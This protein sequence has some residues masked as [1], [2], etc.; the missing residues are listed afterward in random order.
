MQERN[1]N[2]TSAADVQSSVS[3]YERLHLTSTTTEERN[4]N[5]SNLVNSYYDLATLFYEW[6]WGASFHFSNR[7]PYET[8]DEATRRHEFYLASKLNLSGALGK[9][10]GTMNG[11]MNGQSKED[12]E[13]VKEG[14][15]PS[16]ANV[17]VLD[18]GCGIGGPMRNICKFTGADVTGLTLNQYQVD[19]GNELCVADAHFK[20][21]KKS[22]SGL[23]DVR[24]RSVQ[25]DFM[26][27]PFENSSF[28]AAYAIEATCHAPD[29]VGCYSEIYRV[30]KPGAIFACY[31]WCLTD[32]YNALVSS[33]F[34]RLDFQMMGARLTNMMHPVCDLLVFLLAANDASQK[35]VV[36]SACPLGLGILCGNCSS[37]S[38]QCS[39]NSSGFALKSAQSILGTSGSM[40]SVSFGCLSKN[41][42]TCSACSKCPILGLA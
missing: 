29:R 2:L 35:A 39:M 1:K 36:T 14:S 31:E 6:G 28:D 16:M 21:T 20:N 24:C 40:Q 7:H 27:Q 18:V 26:K 9:L 3:E 5:Y 4:S 13:E 30:L 25:G 37:A 38:R 12:D 19:R 23:P 42:K 10:K 8:F 32:R 33:V 15:T 17:K 11:V 22:N 34:W 41:V